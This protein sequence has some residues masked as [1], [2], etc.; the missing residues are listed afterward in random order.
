MAARRPRRGCGLNGAILMTHVLS[1]LCPVRNEATVVPLFYAR[2]EP[3]IARLED[4]YLVRLIFLNNA[5]TDETVAAVQRIRRARSETYLLTTSRDVGYQRSLELGLR[6]IE[7]DI[8]VIIDVDCE[9][10]P[11]MIETFIE[12]YE[13]GCQLVY[14]ERVDRDEPRLLKRT[15]E[16]FYR[17]LQAT[18][19]DEIILNMAEFALFTRDVRDAILA[20]N[21]SFP[22][23]RASIARIG[24]R[25]AA[26]PFKRQRRVAGESH[27]DL[28]GMTIFAV[29]GILA[30]STL[31][32][33]LPIYILPFWFAALTALSIGYGATHSAWCAVLAFLTAVGYLGGSVAV[34]ALYV[35]RTYKNGLMRPNAFINQR[36]SVLPAAIRRDADRASMAA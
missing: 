25:R 9:D 14:G 31:L 17:L 13:L 4:R 7:S 24:F 32:L 22:F 34:T 19:D 15:R 5:S 18:A 16:F 33:R 29:A 28:I 35:A 27:Y 12:H 23:I 2:L 3:V 36:Q 26:V 6:S 10:P 8:Y 1:I 11:E 21:S 20:E 30:S